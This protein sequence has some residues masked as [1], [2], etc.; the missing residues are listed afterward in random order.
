MHADSAT[1]K[2]NPDSADWNVDS[3]WSANGPPNGPGD[4]AT[5]DFST[6]TSLFLSAD[7]EVNEIVFNSS[8]SG[9]KITANGDSP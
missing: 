1:W 9:Y 6:T 4:V 2:T 7:T 3:N 5:F 8:A